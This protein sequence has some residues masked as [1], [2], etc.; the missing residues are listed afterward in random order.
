MITALGESH[1]ENIFRYQIII[2]QPAGKVEIILAAE[3]NATSIF[4]N[5]FWA[6][7]NGSI[8]AFAAD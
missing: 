8:L 7:A 4:L 1:D 5:R 6:T 2:D 3:G